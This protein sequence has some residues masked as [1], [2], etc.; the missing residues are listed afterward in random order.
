LSSESKNIIKVASIY[1]TTVI[2]AGFASGQEIMR[3]F[4]NYYKGGFYGILTAGILFSV[5]GYIVLNKV[6]RERIRNYDEFLFPTVGWLLGRIMEIVV[7]VFMFSVFSIMLAGLGSILSAKLSI[8]FGISIVIMSVVCMLLILTDI[9]GI[10]AMSTLVTP[11]LVIGI[12]G[13]GLYVI[14]FK[15]TTVFNFTGYF[16][17]ITG[18][19][20]FSA[21]L[22]VSYNSIMSITVMCSLLPYL[23]T[24]K[25][26]VMGGVIGGLSLCAMAFI[27]NT[28][29]ILFYPEVGLK[30]FPVLYIIEKYS[31]HLTNFYTFILWLAMFTSAV[32]SGYCF[33]DRISSK[34]S[35][36]FKL[37]TVATCIIV[38]PLSSLGFSKLISVI[39]PIFGYIGLFMMFAVLLQGLNANPVI[40]SR[41]NVF[42]KKKIG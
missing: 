29:I 13:I 17:N 40:T 7:I 19:W 16:K 9:K 31:R 32:T 20:F 1:M 15:D 3:F 18:N 21:V 8:S 41:K 10:V 38:V 4:S 35:L 37:V 6:Y 26:A 12:F 11:V 24:R 22:Y 42:I 28:V 33:V 5:I 36:N 34:F 14:A 23:K 25:T 39:Y 27:I 2:G 30:E